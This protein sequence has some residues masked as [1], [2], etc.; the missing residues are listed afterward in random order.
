MTALPDIFTTNVINSSPF[1]LYII[2][3]ILQY[4]NQGNKQKCTIIEILFVY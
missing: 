2:L 1:I 4:S 3:Y